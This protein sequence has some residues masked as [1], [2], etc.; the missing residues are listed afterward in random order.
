M[1]KRAEGIDMLAMRLG[2]YPRRFRWLRREIEVL[3]VERVWT[4]RRQWPRL[5]RRRMYA[6]HSAQGPFEL[7]HDLTRDV[8]TIVRAPAPDAPLPRAFRGMRSNLYGQRLAVVR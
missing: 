7:C 4:V 6:V 5:V 2:Y 1:N 3:R 8:W